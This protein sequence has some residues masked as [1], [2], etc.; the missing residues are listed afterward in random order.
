M[1]RVGEALAR[2]EAS[3]VYW[4]SN[5]LDLRQQELAAAELAR[6]GWQKYVFAG[7]APM[8]E[9]RML[10]LYADE[11][12]PA[13]PIVCLDA[14]YPEKIELTHRDFLGALMSLGMKRELLGDIFVKSG[15]AKIFTTAS[16]SSVILQELSSVGRAAVR[17]SQAEQLPAELALPA[18]ERSVTV[19][20]LRLDTVLGAA[21]KKSRTASAQLVAGGGV[22]V[23]ARPVTSVSYLLEEGDAISVRGLGKYRLSK[24]GGQSKKDRTFITIEK[25]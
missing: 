4:C 15:C 25:F 24:I 3:G 10:I 12:P 18:E 8:C 23:N 17:L 5:F 1:K 14:L 21:L 13:P 16:A 19:A 22:S 9:R 6:A 11:V 7:G 20:S 2:C